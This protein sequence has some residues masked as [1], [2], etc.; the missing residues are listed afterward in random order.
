LTKI[1]ELTL[2]MS[3]VSLNAEVQEVPEPRTVRTRMGYTTKVSNATIKDDTGSI[4]L[5]LW[6]KKSEEISEG[7]KVEIKGGYVAE[8]RGELQLNVPRKGEINKIE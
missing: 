3:D 6:G 1:N 4:T 5:P 2:G 7:D 8:F